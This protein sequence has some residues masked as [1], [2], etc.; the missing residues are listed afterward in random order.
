MDPGLPPQTLHGDL[1]ADEH[2]KDRQ[3][4]H[5]H[6]KAHE[7]THMHRKHDNTRDTTRMYKTHK[8]LGG[9]KYNW[10]VPGIE[11][12]D[13]QEAIVPTPQTPLDDDDDDDG[14]EG[15]FNLPTEAGVH[16][17]PGSSLPAATA[18]AA[19]TGEAEGSE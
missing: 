15:N 12:L 18:A 1:R 5:A 2:A 9:G 3:R 10:G 6:T 13:E 7:A 8:K 4:T 14:G 16:T 17:V 11:V 19:E